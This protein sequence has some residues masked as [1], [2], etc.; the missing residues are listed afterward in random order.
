MEYKHSCVIGAQGYYR[1][2]VLVHLDGGDMRTDSY[3]D[4]SVKTPKIKSCDKNKI[5]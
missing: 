1:D 4:S 5:W 2:F 3:N